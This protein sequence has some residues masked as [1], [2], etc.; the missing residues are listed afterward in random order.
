MLDSARISSIVSGSSAVETAGDV[1]RHGFSVQTH[2]DTFELS[3]LDSAE[4]QRWKDDLYRLIEIE[5][6][7]ELRTNAVL[8]SRSS[9]TEEKCHF[10]SHS[11]NAFRSRHVCSQW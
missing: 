7:S 4:I 2:A 9:D 5:S 11:F 10:C 6:H 3:S 8:S 1:A